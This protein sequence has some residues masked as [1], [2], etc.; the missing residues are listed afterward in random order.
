MARGDHPTQREQQIPQHVGNNGQRVDGREVRPAADHV[1]I[2]RAI[3]RKVELPWWQIDHRDAE[4]AAW[5]PARHHPDAPAEGPRSSVHQSTRPRCR[6]RACKAAL[7]RQSRR[8]PTCQNAPQHSPRP[9]AATRVERACAASRRAGAARRRRTPL[10][11]RRRPR[12]RRAANRRSSRRRHPRAEACAAV[13]WHAGVA[14]RFAPVRPHWPSVDARPRRP[15]PPV[16]PH[17]SERLLIPVNLRFESGLSYAICRAFSLYARGRASSRPAPTPPRLKA[18]VIRPPSRR[19]RHLL[20]PRAEAEVEAAVEA[21][22]FWWL[23]CNSR[24]IGSS[25]VHE[26]I[27]GGAAAEVGTSPPLQRR[28]RRPNYRGLPPLRPWYSR[29][30]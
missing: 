9:D 3:R 12:P 30:D 8:R 11:A 5:R 24:I 19:L 14:A 23:G 16:A 10:P 6:E 28:C 17:N 22:L 13:G 1:L 15:P 26:L 20:P 18:R 27:I 2:A 25:G 4:L 7:S 29:R 21:E